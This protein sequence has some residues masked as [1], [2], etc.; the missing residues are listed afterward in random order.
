MDIHIDFEIGEQV[1]YIH[2]KTFKAVQN[3]LM[4]IKTHTNKEGTKIKYHVDVI[5]I[6][7]ASHSEELYVWGVFKTKEL[8][9]KSL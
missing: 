4:D 9:L 5:T 7:G 2:P 1:W 6:S 8:L 3:V